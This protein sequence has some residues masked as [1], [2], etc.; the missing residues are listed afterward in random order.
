[1]LPSLKQ[2]RRRGAAYGFHYSMVVASGLLL[3]L[4]TWFCA[5]HLPL[6]LNYWTIALLS[7]PTA[8]FMTLLVMSSAVQAQLRNWPLFGLFLLKR[9]VVLGGLIF[10]YWLTAQAAAQLAVL[11]GS[12]DPTTDMMK[13]FSSGGSDGLLLG[14]VI[15]LLIVVIKAARRK[16]M[17]EPLRFRELTAGEP[18][19]WASQAH[20]A[21]VNV[22]TDTGHYVYWQGRHTPELFTQSVHAEA[23]VCRLPEEMR[24]FYA[25][26]LV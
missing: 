6:V 3:V 17:W 25:T 12:S 22:K 15:G 9:I 11:A 26:Q 19:M 8:V 2:S 7:L 4:L 1:M 21:S 14:F 24:S 18:F 23:E 16:Y 5:T 13:L 20:T 10:A